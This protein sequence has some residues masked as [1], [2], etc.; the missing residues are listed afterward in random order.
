M[1]AVFS[2]AGG[3]GILKYFASINLYTLQSGFYICHCKMHC[4]QSVESHCTFVTSC[5]A[6]FTCFGFE[7]SGAPNDNF[8]KNICSEDDLRFVKFS[9]CLPLLGFSNIQKMVYLL[10]FNGFLTLKR[11]PRI[12]GSLFSG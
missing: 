11:S 3:R 2:L 10:I 6:S 8:R 4:I 1:W 9:A 7:A 12:F 5:V